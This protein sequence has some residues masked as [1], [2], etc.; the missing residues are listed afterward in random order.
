VN[1]AKD[2]L[3]NAT[4]QDKDGNSIGSVRDVVTDAKGKARE[5]HV[6]AGGF[7]GVGTKVVSVPAKN[8]KYEQDRNVLI[9]SMEGSNQ[10]LAGGQN[11]T[12]IKWFRFRE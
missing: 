3:S 5:I 1:A 9:T 12:V 2:T 10:S 4:V 11:L 8:L 6:D 7:L